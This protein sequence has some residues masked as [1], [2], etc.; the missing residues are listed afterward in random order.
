MG[1]RSWTSAIPFFVS[2]IQGQFKAVPIAE[3]ATHQSSNGIHNL[4]EG[5]LVSNLFAEVDKIPP[6]ID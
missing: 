4:H 5:F 3:P 6:R 1:T 2:V